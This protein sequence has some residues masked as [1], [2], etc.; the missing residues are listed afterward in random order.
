[1]SGPVM[2]PKQYIETQ[3]RILEM[4][5][6]ANSLDIETFL[7]CIRNAETMAPMIDP[8]MYMKAQKN[9]SAIKKLAEIALT[10]QGAFNET[11]QAV[12]ETAASGYMQKPEG[13]L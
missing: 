13:A 5:K 9:L 7:L 12:L 10:M 11:F 2:Q 1:M 8:T 3:M 4:A 6:I